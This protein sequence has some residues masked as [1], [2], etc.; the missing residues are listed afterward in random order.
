M[1]SS[2]GGTLLPSAAARAVLDL[3]A[4][5]GKAAAEV[6]LREMEYLRIYGAVS[7]P[8]LLD[9]Y[10]RHRGATTV[11]VCLDRLKDDPGGRVRSGLEESFLPFLDTH[12][13]PRPRLNA[14]LTI[15][16]DR[17]QVD[18]FW[19][20]ADLVGELDDFHSH[21]TRRA[22][23]KDRRCDRRLGVAGFG[24]VRITRDQVEDEPFQV[25]ADLR[26]LLRTTVRDNV[27][28]SWR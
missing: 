28:A 27:R 15:G 8:T 11:G 21:G 9:R 25:A 18:C 17:F 20:D 22:F 12:Q 14:W 19:P 13:I 5:K 2:D 26:S 6:A 24:V 4:D 1:G 23:R 10:P 16:D 3:A 7:I